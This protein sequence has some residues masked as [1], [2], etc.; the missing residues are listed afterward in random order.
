MNSAREVITERYLEE[1]DEIFAI[2]KIGRAATD[3][4]VSNVIQLAQKMDLRNISI[5]CTR[6][7]VNKNS[8]S[9]SHR[10][11]YLFTGNKS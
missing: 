4:G 7:E 10:S 6:A 3:Q 8:H 2:C 5:V 1:C 11:T 9:V